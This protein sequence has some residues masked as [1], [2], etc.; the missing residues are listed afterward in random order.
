MKIKFKITLEDSVKKTKKDI[1][2]IHSY[3][4]DFWK[5]YPEVNQEIE[6]D[7]IKNFPIGCSIFEHTDISVFDACCF[8]WE[9]NNMSCD[10][11]RYKYFYNDYQN[12][13]SCGD[14]RFKL[15][16]ITFERI[17]FETPIN[18]KKIF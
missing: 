7:K 1:F 13:F 3:N 5:F 12:I 9:E 14:D 11:N 8:Y 15:I 4:T 10:C 6:I 17:E 16:N 18:T 2:D